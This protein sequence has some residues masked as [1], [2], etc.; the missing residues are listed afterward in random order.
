MARLIAGLLCL[1]AAFAAVPAPASAAGGDPE[2]ANFINIVNE[3]PTRVYYR[4]KLWQRDYTFVMAGRT[5]KVPVPTESS[6]L[7]TVEV[8]AYMRDPNDKCFA[9]VPLKGSMV[10]INTDVRI[11]C[12]AHR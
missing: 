9:S 2:P 11:E 12:K 4:V 1:A 3:T 5:V 8:E 7:A 10:V 6:K